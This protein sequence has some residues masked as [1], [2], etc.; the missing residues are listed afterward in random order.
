M[1]DQKFNGGVAAPFFGRIVHTAGAP[2]RLALRFGA[3]MQ[4]MSVVRLPGA[5]F[6]VTIHDPIRL[7][8]TGN[9][10]RDV[11]AAVA[12]V[13]AFIEARIRE[14]PAEWFWVHKRWPQEDY[15]DEG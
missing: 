9:R 4:P 5:R 13:N 8:D 6:R 14:R 12:Q 7:T 15:I 3:V 1:N 11:E 2:S 10:E